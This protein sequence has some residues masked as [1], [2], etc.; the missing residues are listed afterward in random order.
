[1]AKKK[2]LLGTIVAVIL[3]VSS[4]LGGQ[5]GIF[6]IGSENKSY[7]I[8]INMDY[9]DRSQQHIWNVSALD[10]VS[11]LTTEWDMASPSSV[12]VNP[13]LFQ[14][15]TDYLKRHKIGVE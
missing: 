7:D 13:E 11:G 14:S 9:D 2:T 1:M 3:L 6:K 5:A 4:Y 8:T 10:T 15:I 12:A